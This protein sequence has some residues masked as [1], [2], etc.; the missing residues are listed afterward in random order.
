MTKFEI[1]KTYWTRSICMHDCIFEIEIISR[2]EKTVTYMYNNRKRRS[3]IHVSNDCE[4]IVPDNYSMAPTFHANEV[5]EE[6]TPEETA[7]EITEPAAASDN[8]KIYV[9]ERLSIDNKYGYIDFAL[10]GDSILYRMYFRNRK[11]FE[12][13]LDYKYHGKPG[14]CVRGKARAAITSAVNG[15]IENNLKKTIAVMM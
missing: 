1:G 9:I 5:M 15:M 14:A 11:N 2:T 13:V 3:K 6:E 12:K 4:W 10:E 8:V 7:G